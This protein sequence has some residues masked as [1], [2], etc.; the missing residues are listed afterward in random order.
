[1]LES[2]SGSASRVDLDNAGNPRALDCRISRLRELD[3]VREPAHR[4]Q[5]AVAAEI[6]IATAI[7]KARIRFSIR[8][9]GAF[10]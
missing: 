2:E 5:A 4:A 7:A 1:M 6:E 8:E 10:S 3:L 9:R